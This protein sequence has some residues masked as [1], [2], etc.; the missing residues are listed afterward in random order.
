VLTFLE[1]K[2]LEQNENIRKLQFR[3]EELEQKSSRDSRDRLN[4]RP[5]PSPSF[6]ALLLPSF[7][8]VLP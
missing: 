7:S 4:V 3:L 8:F 1:Q 6:A 5:D 2:T